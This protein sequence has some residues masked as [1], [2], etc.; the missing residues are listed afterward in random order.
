MPPDKQLSEEQIAD[1]KKWIQDGAA[2]ARSEIVGRSQGKTRVNTN[3][4]KSHWAWQP[5]KAA[6]VPQ[7]Q[8][9]NWAR[10]DIDRFVLNKLER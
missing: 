3:S 10:S 6:A 1:I 2:L 8:D 7:V 9:P 5:L 4:R